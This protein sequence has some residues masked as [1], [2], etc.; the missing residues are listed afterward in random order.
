MVAL[1][2]GL[3]HPRIL[4]CRRPHRGVI[5]DVVRRGGGGDGLGWSCPHS[6]SEDGSEDLFARA[7]VVATAG[8]SL[9]AEVVVA[10]GV[11]VVA[12]AGDP[13]MQ[14]W[15]PPLVK[16]PEASFQRNSCWCSV[17]HSCRN[18]ARGP[19]V[20]ECNNICLLESRM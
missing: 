2:A 7:G 1:C 14:R 6:R 3:P 12:V 15:S 18:G 11:E 9:G 8:E 20:R 5:Q 19:L 13:S 16:L 10:A 17:V 4:P